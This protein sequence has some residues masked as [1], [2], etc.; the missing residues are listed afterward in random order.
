MTAANTFFRGAALSLSVLASSA[1]ADTNTPDTAPHIV[2]DA[3]NG[4]IYDEKKVQIMD[5]RMIE[6]LPLE[7]RL[8]HTPVA[9]PVELRDPAQ[10]HAVP[11]RLRHYV[12]Q[13]IKE[14]RQLTQ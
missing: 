3:A 4:R 5:P 9:A 6:M 2:C 14:A 12:N 10:V 7:Q 8:S 1:Y 13:C 11:Q